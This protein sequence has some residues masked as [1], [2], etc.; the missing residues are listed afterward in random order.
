MIPGADPAYIEFQTTIP[1]VCPKKEKP[2]KTEK[3]KEKKEEAE[4]EEEED[5][6]ITFEIST[7]TSSASAPRCASGNAFDLVS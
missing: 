5:C 1:I 3:N 2:K 7:R 4:E 6:C